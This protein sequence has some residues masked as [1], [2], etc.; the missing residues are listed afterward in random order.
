MSLNEQYKAVFSQLSCPRVRNVTITDGIIICIMGSYS[1]S[2]YEFLNENSYECP[3]TNTVLM[4]N[5]DVDYHIKFNGIIYVSKN[6]KS[7]SHIT[8]KY[9]YFN[10][11]SVCKLEFV[12]APIIGI[13][14]MYK[15]ITGACT[16]TK[17]EWGYNDEALCFYDESGNTDAGI[18]KFMPNLIMWPNHTFNLGEVCGKENSLLTFVTNEPTSVI[19]AG[20]DFLIVNKCHSLY[21]PLITK[22]PACPYGFYQ[23]Y[24]NIDVCASTVNKYNLCGRIGGFLIHAI[25][26]A[27]TKKY[28][29]AFL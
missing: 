9:V 28:T 21:T 24:N 18:F 13:C 25:D 22:G 27:T 11:E 5:S 19:N 10:H 17:I 26:Q 16:K 4:I 14:S 2:I 3:S 23:R 20:V 1:D 8:G 7:H 29:Q 15:P 12:H 6:C